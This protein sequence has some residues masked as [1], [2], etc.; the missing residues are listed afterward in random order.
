MNTHC[1]NPLGHLGGPDNL[2]GDS[3]L[4]VPSPFTLVSDSDRSAESNC[5]L[6]L[7]REQDCSKGGGQ[8]RRNAFDGERL[9]AGSVIYCRR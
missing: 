1:R 7:A 5:T 3:G 9:A 8:R 2:D 6:L 4:L